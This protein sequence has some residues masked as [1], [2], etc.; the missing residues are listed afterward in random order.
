MNKKS[1]EASQKAM[2]QMLNA[3]LEGEESSS[4]DDE[5]DSAIKREWNTVDFMGKCRFYFSLYL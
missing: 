1:A 2:Q 5:K 4:D 3:N